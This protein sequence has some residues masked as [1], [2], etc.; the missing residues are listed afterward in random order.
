MSI[1]S[2]FSMYYSDTYVGYTI[3]GV[4]HPMFVEDVT[5][6]SEVYDEAESEDREVEEVVEFLYQ[7]HDQIIDHLIFR[8]YYVSESGRTHSVEVPLTEILLENPKLG[9]V[10]D[11]GKWQWVTY[12]PNQSV[13]K[14]LCHRRL[15]NMNISP[16]GLFN[17]FNIRS[18]EELLDNDLLLLEGGLHYKGVQIASREGTTLVLSKEFAIMEDYI[19]SLLPETLCL[20]I[21]H[22]PL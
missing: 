6:I 2:D 13:K 1:A 20:E 15:N 9:Y 10:H 16:E 4:V 21:E 5:Y 22:L 14:G 18:T 11:R 19:K 17:L 8:G 3:D 12:S 7:E